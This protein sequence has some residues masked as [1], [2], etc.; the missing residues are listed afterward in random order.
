M[1]TPSPRLARYKCPLIALGVIAAVVWTMGGTGVL[2]T[3]LLQV[4]FPVCGETVLEE[5]ESPDRMHKAVSFTAGCG[6][7]GGNSYGVSILRANQDLPEG[8]SFNVVRSGGGFDLR[9]DWLNADTLRLTMN[10]A[11]RDRSS[12]A[13]SRVLGVEIVYA[14]TSRVLHRP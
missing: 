13:V 3:R 1:R 7:A 9:M 14:D 11:V 6:A 12:L 10:Q 4:A 5:V 2:S 8:Y